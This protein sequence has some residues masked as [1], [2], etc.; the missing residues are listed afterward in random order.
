M[1]SAW[2]GSDLRRATDCRLMHDHAAACRNSLL[3]AFNYGTNMDAAYRCSNQQLAPV[4]TP[5]CRC[6]RTTRTHGRRRYALIGILVLHGRV[7]QD[8]Q[9]AGITPNHI[10]QA[11]NRCR[12]WYAVP[13]DTLPVLPVLGTF[14]LSLISYAVHRIT[15]RTPLPAIPALQ[16]SSWQRLQR[17]PATPAALQRWARL[18][19]Q[20]QI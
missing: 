4:S 7:W 5:L 15:Y 11:G 18:S 13:H 8:M 2:R 1:G 6:V 19:K 10:T 12:A 14:V 16:R 3:R 9:R 20:V 17:L